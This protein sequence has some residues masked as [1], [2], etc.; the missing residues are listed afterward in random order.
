M[1]EQKRQRI[2]EAGWRFGDAATFLDLT[3]EESA[4]IDR[5]LREESPAGVLVAEERQG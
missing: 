4:E 5:R 2:E 1:E 3:A